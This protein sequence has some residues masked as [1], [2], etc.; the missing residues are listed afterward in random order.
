VRIVPLYTLK[1]CCTIIATHGVKVTSQACYTHA[2]SGHQH[3]SNCTPGITLWVISEKKMDGWMKTTQLNCTHN[4]EYFYFL[5]SVLLNA[6][7]CKDKKE[8][9]CMPVA[10]IHFFVKLG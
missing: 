2:P 4:C 5:F 1:R 7:G 3:R 10:R 9:K 6:L 8:M